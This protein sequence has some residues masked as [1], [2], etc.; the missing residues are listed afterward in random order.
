V[1]SS[2]I[3][4]KFITLIQQTSIQFNNFDFSK[5][6]TQIS[7]LSSVKNAIRLNSKKKGRN[8]FEVK[9]QTEHGQVCLLPTIL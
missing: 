3:R 5:N 7:K 2:P 8:L 4:G 6:Q 1:S 9:N